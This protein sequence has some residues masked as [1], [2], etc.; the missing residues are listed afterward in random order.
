MYQF[1]FVTMWLALK[2]AVC[3]FAVDL[4]RRAGVLGDSLCALANGMLRQFPWKEQSNSSLYFSTGNGGALAVSSQMWCLFCNSFEDIMNKWIHDAHG[5]ARYASVGVD[6][7]EYLVNVDA[8]ALSP[9]SMF[10]IP[11]VRTTRLLR[12]R[13]SLF[14]AFGSSFRSHCSTSIND[15]SQ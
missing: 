8:K 10:A 4:F 2:R 13:C 12:C 5:F 11:P 1:S 7:F 3:F 9:T 14:C 15:N 6:L